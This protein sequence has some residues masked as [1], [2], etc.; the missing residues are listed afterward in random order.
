MPL[1]TI[2]TEFTQQLGI[3]HP[4]LLAGM[5]NISLSHLAAAVSNAGGLGTYI[6]SDKNSVTKTE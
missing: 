5:A 4:V 2:Q 6:Y 3:T 1:D